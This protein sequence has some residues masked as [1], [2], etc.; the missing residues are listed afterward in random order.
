MEEKIVLDEQ[1]AQQQPEQRM[2]SQEEVNKLVGAAKAEAQEKARRQM[3]AEFQQRM[4][5]QRS[6]QAQA[7]QAQ[8][9]P[10]LDMDRIYQETRERLQ[11]EMQQQNMEAELKRIAD[12]YNSR[13]EE[14]KEKDP[15][16]AELMGTFNSR[17]FPAV[18][19]LA[20]EVDNTGDVV[21]ELV[22]N[23]AK[24]VEI[25]ALAKD[26]EN[27]ARQRMRSLSDSIKKNQAAIEEEKLAKTR[28]PL[29]RMSPSVNSTSGNGTMSVADLRAQ[30]W[31]RR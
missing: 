29:D 12:T 28:S 16:F 6:Q 7:P 24:L 19:F 8:A 14:M 22:K 17:K 13:V 10:E 25:N 9:A 5:Q 30:D 2:L 26:D 20:A 21:K 3:E 23:P 31:L 1:V 18:A 11:R 4:E 27:W 15:E